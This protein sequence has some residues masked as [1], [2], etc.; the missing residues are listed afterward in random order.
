MILILTT[1]HK[2]RLDVALIRSGRVDIELKFKYAT[3][4][5]M[6]KLFRSFYDAIVSQ[7]CK[8]ASE[9]A[10]N[11]SNLLK[12]HGKNVTMAQLQHFFVLHRKDSAQTAAADYNAIIE[13]ISSREEET[14]EE[15]KD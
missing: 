12:K 3:D 1:N 10:A 5:Q 4:G 9:F 6:E 7:N 11:L 13:I 8:Y 2:E 15:R 14:D